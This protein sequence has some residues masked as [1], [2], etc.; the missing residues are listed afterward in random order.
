MGGMKKGTPCGRSAFW[1]KGEDVP[2]I[3]Q[4]QIKESCF[5]SSC[6]KSRSKQ[7][8]ARWR[9]RRCNDRRYSYKEFHSQK[10]NT[11]P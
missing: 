5:D 1:G 3:L 11:F 10:A 9:F 6:D 8:G 7:E 2:E 4:R